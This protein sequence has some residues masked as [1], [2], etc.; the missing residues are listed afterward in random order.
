MVKAAQEY[1]HQYL[2]ITDHSHSL[3]IARG[4][5]IERLKQQREQIDEIQQEVGENFRILHGVEVE[6]LADGSLDHPDEI[7]EELD[8]VIASLHTSLR[9]PQDVI[10]TR[11]IT[12]IHNPHVDMIAH[13]TGRLIGS[14]DPADVDL[15]AVLVEAAEHQVVLSINANP[16]RLD[17]SDVHA[18]R[19]LEMGCLLAVNT[20]AH[21][22]DH[23]GFQQYGVGVARRA[24]VEPDP[25]INTWSY[26][27]LRAWLQS[28]G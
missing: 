20:D 15:D 1:G 24:W 16:E 26:D 19:A 12:A 11:L 4:L 13:P 18:R 23:F 9:Q 10:T 6:I 17:L 25:V 14:R 22:P 2:A 5:D 21:H 3:G 8:L 7:L 28:R 27:R